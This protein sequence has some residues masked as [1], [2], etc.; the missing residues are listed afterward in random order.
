MSSRGR[1][2]RTPCCRALP[3][4]DIASATRIYLPRAKRRAHRAEDPQG[5]PGL[6]PGEGIPPPVHRQDA[7]GRVRTVRLSAHRH[8]GPRVRRGAPRQGRRG[9]GQGGLPFH[10]PRRAR[11]G[12][13]L[14]PHRALCA[15]HGGAPRRGGPPLPPLAR[16]QG[17]AR[18]EHA[19]RPLP[20]V[21]A[22]RFRRGRDRLRLRRPRDSPPH[23][24]EPRGPRHAASP[25]SATPTAACSTPAWPGS[26]WR[27][28]PSRC[29]APSTSSE[30][31]A[32]KRRTSMLAEIAG[33]SAA[34]EILELIRVEKHAR[35]DR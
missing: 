32:R 35:G 26:G 11:R 16:G 3:S 34:K 31:S 33:E 30:R 15:V 5:V 27:S 13:A 29:C 1:V 12:H 23:A 20:R 19:A 25:A 2:T 14:R 28:S 21:H 7:A 18:R 4:L 6:P 10:G 22:G 9:D 17:V 24:G 8:A